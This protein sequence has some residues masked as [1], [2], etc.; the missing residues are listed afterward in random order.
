MTNIQLLLTS[1]LY[2]GKLS[3]SRSGRLDKG[4]KDP[5]TH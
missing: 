2:G 5:G 4:V 3:A 1:V